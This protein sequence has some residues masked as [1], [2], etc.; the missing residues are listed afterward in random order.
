MPFGRFL[1]VLHG[2]SGIAATINPELRRTL[3]CA[4]VAPDG[5]L[6]VDETGILKSGVKSPGV[7]RQYSGLAGRMEN[8]QVGVFLTYRSPLG[9]AFINRSLY[10]PKEWTDDQL[11][12]REAGIPE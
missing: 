5:V 6:I 4:L 1:P 11:R 8:S 7:A 10:L 2:T 3:I 12:R 9:T